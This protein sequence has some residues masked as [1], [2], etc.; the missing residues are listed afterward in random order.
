MF[1]HYHLCANDHR[2]RYYNHYGELRKAIINQTS[3][4]ITPLTIGV[5]VYTIIDIEDDSKQHVT[6]TQWILI[7]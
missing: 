4:S 1:R 5:F 2:N 3:G 6:S 7:V